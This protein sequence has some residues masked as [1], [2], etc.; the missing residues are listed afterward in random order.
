[1][2]TPDLNALRE[3]AGPLERTMRSCWDCNG[4]HAHLRAVEAFVVW[5]FC[6]GRYLYRGVDITEYDGEPPTRCSDCDA[7]YTPTQAAV[8]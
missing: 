8:A 6:C 4:A 3:Q 1:M 5:C 2:T 7:P